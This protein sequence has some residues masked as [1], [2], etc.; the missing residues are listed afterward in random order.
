VVTEDEATV[1]LDILEEALTQ[2]E[3]EE[4]HVAELAEM[5]A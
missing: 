3:V 4:G 5:G 1:A 2:V